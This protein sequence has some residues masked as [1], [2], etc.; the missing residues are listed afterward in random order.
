MNL[1]ST[2]YPSLTNMTDINRQL[3]SI[4]GFYW[5]RMSVLHFEDKASSELITKIT[6]T[7]ATATICAPTR[8][9]ILIELPIERAVLLWV[10]WVVQRG[11]ALQ[12]LLH[13]KQVPQPKWHTEEFIKNYQW[14]A[15]GRQRWRTSWWGRRKSEETTEEH[16]TSTEK[17]PPPTKE[18][19]PLLK[20]IQPSPKNIHSPPK[21]VSTLEMILTWT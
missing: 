12:E 6:S 4:L 17:H 5:K 16:L 11:V 10:R 7:A 1:D 2:L 13:P 21:K 18:H 3:A 15:R 14:R 9:S 8:P 19:S 20:N